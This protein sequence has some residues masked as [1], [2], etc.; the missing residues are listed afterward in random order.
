[1]G[2]TSVAMVELGD[3]VGAGGVFASNGG[4]GK[5]CSSVAGVWVG[6]GELLRVVNRSTH[7]ATSDAY[8]TP[9]EMRC[10][11]FNI[12]VT[13]SEVVKLIGKRH[14]LLVV[15][16]SKVLLKGGK[17]HKHTR[18]KGTVTHVWFNYQA[19]FKNI[20]RT[21]SGVAK[22]PSGFSSLGARRVFVAVVC[23]VCVNGCTTCL[24]ISRRWHHVGRGGVFHRQFRASR[25]RLA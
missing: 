2:L 16:F 14:P 5:E 20:F 13:R 24:W 21:P 17:T 8:A 3:G 19:K 9:P 25:C 11:L 6:S 1:M 4:V 23:A 7:A 18:N 22:H 12:A 15:L 10:V